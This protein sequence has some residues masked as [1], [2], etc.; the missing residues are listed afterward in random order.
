M[1]DRVFVGRLKMSEAEEKEGEERENQKE[2][3]EGRG[4]GNKI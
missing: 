2:I 1:T 4:E 3:E